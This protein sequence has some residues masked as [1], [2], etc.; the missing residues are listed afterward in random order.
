MATDGG[1]A[2]RFSRAACSNCCGEM[3]SLTK[4][5]GHKGAEPTCGMEVVG[6]GHPYGAFYRA[7]EGAKRTRERRSPVAWWTLMG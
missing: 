3:N 4:H 7:S 1:R 5:C 2:M 6:D